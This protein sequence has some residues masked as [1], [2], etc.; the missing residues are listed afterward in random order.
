MQVF[1]TDGTSTPRVEVEYPLGHVRRRAEGLPKLV[2]KFQSNLAT[3]FPPDQCRRLEELFGD[4]PR[5]EQTAM[6]EL[7]EKLKAES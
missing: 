3:R 6:D 7:M 5:L 1:F 2:E 4:Q